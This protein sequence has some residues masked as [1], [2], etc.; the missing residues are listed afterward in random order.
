MKLSQ[1]RTIGDAERAFILHRLK[2]NKGRKTLTA[3]DL[4]MTKATL[5]QKLQRY[6]SQGFKIP[7]AVNKKAKV[8][9]QGYSP[10]PKQPIRDM[11]IK[12]FA[13][14]KDLERAVILFNLEANDG[15]RTLTAKQLNIS[16]ERFFSRL[17]KFRAQGCVIPESA[18]ENPL[19]R[20]IVLRRV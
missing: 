7:G 3:R 8:I 20:K 12:E 11:S 5:F 9:P 17:S 4:G 1:F 6:R 14:R 19:A 18:R 10:P 2:L 15:N 16:K 13:N